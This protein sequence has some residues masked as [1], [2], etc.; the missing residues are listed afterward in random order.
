MKRYKTA[1]LIVC[2]FL[3]FST[4]FGCNENVENCHYS[5]YS[6]I[7]QDFS[8]T[9]EKLLSE[10]S[11]NEFNSSNF[12]FPDTTLTYEW[13]SMLI[14][15]KEGLSNPTKASFGYIL[16]D[17]NADKIPEL[18]LVRDDYTILAIFTLSDN[19]PY[20]LGAFWSRQKAVV[21]DSYELY[22]MRSGGAQDFEY[23]I[24]ELNENNQLSVIRKFGSDGG[25]YYEEV[26]DNIVT[27]TKTGFDE[28]M[29]VHTFEFG[30]DWYNNKICS[31]P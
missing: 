10:S 3:G 2:L 28:L 12:I 9:V 8:D 1:F 20:L 5:P 15:A 25:S 14:D 13:G 23:T 6:Q 7:L 18:F 29:S 27:I 11:E 19:K 21:L 4:L 30:E 24:E 22:V 16:K 17:I 26:N 31:L